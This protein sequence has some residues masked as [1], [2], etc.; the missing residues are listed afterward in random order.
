MVKTNGL[1]YAQ[2]RLL[3]WIASNPGLRPIKFVRQGFV[4]DAQQG[5]IYRIIRTLVARK[6]IVRSANG[7]YKLTDSGRDA[8]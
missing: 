6:L 1:G 4:S 8:I 5:N 7:K 2:R 3:K